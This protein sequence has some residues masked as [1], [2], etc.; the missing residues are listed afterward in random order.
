MLMR[1]R[2]REDD[3]VKNER[4]KELE[5][6]KRKRNCEKRKIKEQKEEDLTFKVGIFE[7]TR[8]CEHRD[9]VEKDKTMIINK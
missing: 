9:L 3:E 7:E 1:L 6:E 2:G 8:E 5:E 4:T